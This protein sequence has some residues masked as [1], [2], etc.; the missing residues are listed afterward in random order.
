MAVMGKGRQGIRQIHYHAIFHYRFHI[1]IYYVFL[2][3]VFSVINLSLCGCAVQPPPL[4]QKNGKF[5]GKIDDWIIRH[6]WDSSY[7]RGLSY[8]E[9]E[10]WDLAVEQ[11]L[12]AIRQRPEDQWRV[13]SYGMNIL[14]EYFPYRELG[15]VYLRQ[16]LLEEAIE[17]L[18]Y[19]LQSAD[20]AKTKY[21][22]NKAHKLWLKQTGLDRVPP[23]LE[24]INPVDNKSHP[25]YTNHSNYQ[26]AGQAIDDFFVNEIFINEN[27]VYV[28]LAQPKV[29]FRKNVTLHTGMNSV[30]YRIIDL[31]GHEYC[32][33]IKIF[34]DQKGPTVI[35]T[36]I[37]N[38]PDN[39]QIEE[40]IIKGVVFDTG[41][42]YELIV[43]GKEIHLSQGEQIHEF[44]MAFP[45]WLKT[46]LFKAKDYAGNITIGDFS[47]LFMSSEELAFSQKDLPVSKFSIHKG[48]EIRVCANTPFVPKPLSNRISRELSKGPRIYIQKHAPIVYEPVIVVQGW[49]ESFSEISEIRINDHLI[50][51]NQENAGIMKALR[52]LLYGARKIYYFTRRIEGLR[53]GENLLTII[54]EDIEG[55]RVSKGITVECRV[56]EI[57]K[58]GNRWCMAILPFIKHEINDLPLLAAQRPSE[59][60]FLDTFLQYSFFQTERFRMVERERIDAIMHELEF[61]LNNRFD[62]DMCSK[63]GRLLSTEVL[64]MGSMQERLEG[65]DRILQIL[66]RLIDVETGQVLSIKDA[67]NT[68]NNHQ[69][70]DCLLNSLAQKFLE[71]FPILHGRIMDK[72]LRKLEL[73]L[74]A[75]D[76]LKQGMKVLIYREQDIEERQI[77]LGEAKVSEVGVDSSS[78]LPY[79]AGLLKKVQVGDLVITK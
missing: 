21:Y 2:L 60:A 66:A 23:T 68:W 34:L 57:Q 15:I 63:L 14:D 43:G 35:V 50:L 24:L 48:E 73:T 36:N 37:S 19:S 62:K 69:D 27:P 74:G 11:F 58:I 51:T 4:C 75:D 17:A 79:Q 52:K 22:L 13:R 5:Y 49:V 29:S 42:L 41:G 65:Q 12:L 1:F 8:K 7:R 30:P 3:L 45:P 55:E 39:E 64:L 53:E 59:M 54:A 76:L 9:G 25:I 33:E 18:S 6:D 16:S 44:E 67:Y 47:N 10:C 46:P 71:E 56:R 61:Q 26:I 38:D 31:V 70:E 32:E 20:S 40:Y 72:D 78:I 28:D 77:I